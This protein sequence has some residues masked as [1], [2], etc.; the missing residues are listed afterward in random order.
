M[1]DG[2]IKTYETFSHNASV[3]YND[4][5]EN[6]VKYFSEFDKNWELSDFK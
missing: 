1:F 3:F 6:E 2:E 4:V 5:S